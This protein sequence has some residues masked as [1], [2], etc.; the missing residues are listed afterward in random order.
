MKE[1]TR[2]AIV[3]VGM[4][5]FGKGMYELGRIAEQHETAKKM[6]V[7]RDGLEKIGEILEKKAKEQGDE[8]SA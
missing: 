2:G 1:F 6:K 8:E 7:I 4:F 3:A 5:M